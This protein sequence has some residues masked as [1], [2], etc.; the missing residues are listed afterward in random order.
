MYTMEYTL[1]DCGRGGPKDHEILTWRQVGIR[2]R[3][4]RQSKNCTIYGGHGGQRIET[5]KRVNFIA[6]KMHQCIHT[7]SSFH[8]ECVNQKERGSC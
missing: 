5:L 7:H 3:S 8:V 6:I 4:R 2:K 1:L